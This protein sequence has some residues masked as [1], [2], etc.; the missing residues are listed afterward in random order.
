MYGEVKGKGRCFPERFLFRSSTHCGCLHIFVGDGPVSLQYLS[1]S[2]D[3]LGK[4]NLSVPR[5][6]QIVMV[7]RELKIKFKVLSS[8]LKEIQN[9][10]CFLCCRINRWLG[11]LCSL[12]FTA[13]RLEA[14]I[15][16]VI[17][18]SDM[19]PTTGS[20]FVYYLFKGTKKQSLYSQHILIL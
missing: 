3:D 1:A 2:T 14:C 17:L 19:A 11:H 20:L 10:T 5:T 7:M 18:F 6:P 13:A 9:E 12:A 4:L 8:L 15:A 16:H